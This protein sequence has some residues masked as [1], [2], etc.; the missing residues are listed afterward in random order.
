[1]STAPSYRVELWTMHATTFGPSVL[2]ADFENAKNVGWSNWL[3][4]VAS[5]FFTLDAGDAKLAAIRSY[6][7]RAHV[8]IYRGSDLVWAGLWLEHDQND[9]DVILYAYSYLACLYMTLT[10]WATEWTSQQINTIVSDLWTRAK[11]TLSS[12]LVNWVTTG[13]I[14][15]PVTTSGGGTAIVLPLYSVYRKKILLVLQEMAALG[16]SDTTNAVWFEITP[17]GVFNFWKNKQTDQ[18]DVVWNYGDSIVSG[19]QDLSLA[20]SYRNVLYG[21][22]A[23]PNDPTLQVTKTGASLASWGRRETPVFYSFVRDATEIDRITAQRLALAE[24]SDIALGLSFYPNAVIPPG[25]TGAG[26]ALADRVK[27][28]INHGLTN[29]DAMFRVVGVQ[30]LYM[31]GQEYLRARV[32]ERPG[33]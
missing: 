16:A 6:K 22:G 25:A 13:T 5:A 31:R 32:Q 1:V 28:R 21:V 8:K 17:A 2:L 4:E 3:N 10:D 19:F 26:F 33:S 9:R 20:S 12:S 24:R 15:A 14:E 23:S 11:T 29:V 18:S 27:V 30:V 7:G